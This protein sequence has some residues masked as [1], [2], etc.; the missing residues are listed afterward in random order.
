[1]SSLFSVMCLCSLQMFN[2]LV[3]LGDVCSWKVN[4]I[5]DVVIK[6]AWMAFLML[7]TFHI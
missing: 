7:I 4:P 2:N 1:M 5:E 6:S 3:C